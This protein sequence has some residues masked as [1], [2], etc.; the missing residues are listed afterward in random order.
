MTGV[1][2]VRIG[3]LYD[4]LKWGEEWMRYAD[5]LEDRLLLAETRATIAEAEKL[6]LEHPLPG[7]PF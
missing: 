4:A 2:I 5:E 7:V 1:K 6:L 3:S